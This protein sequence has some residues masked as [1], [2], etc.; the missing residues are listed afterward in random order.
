ME[1]TSTISSPRGSLPFHRKEEFRSHDV[2][3]LDGADQRTIELIWSL[4]GSVDEKTNLVRACKSD[5]GDTH[6]V[7]ACIRNMAWLSERELSPCHD[8][9]ALSE[10][11]P[12]GGAISVDL[13]TLLGLQKDL[14]DQVERVVI[15]LLVKANDQVKA[16]GTFRPG[17]MTILDAIASM[18]VSKDGRFDP[19]VVGIL[20]QELD[21]PVGNRVEDGLS[22]VYRKYIASQLEELPE[23]ASLVHEASDVPL[24]AH[25]RPLM[26]LNG[27]DL[28]GAAIARA[29]AARIVM[30]WRCWSCP[31]QREVPSCWLSPDKFSIHETDLEALLKQLVQLLQ[32]GCICY[33]NNDYGVPPTVP[34]EKGP[35]LRQKVAID[36]SN[37]DD[38]I[39]HPQLKLVLDTSCGRDE[40]EEERKT[41]I[42][43]AAQWIPA[44]GRPG[45]PPTEHVDTLDAWIKAIAMC[46][47][48]IGPRALEDASTLEKQSLDKAELT[49]GQKELLRRWTDFCTM[50][51]RARMATFSLT[52]SPLLKAWELTYA[53]SVTKKWCDRSWECIKTSLLNDKSLRSMVGMPEFLEALKQSFMENARYE[54]RVDRSPGH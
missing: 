51:T 3:E 40:P 42:N 8:V 11:F 15:G 37:L 19:N 23:L 7:S 6:A 24:P 21:R 35:L 44:D 17:A 18:L 30:V 2:I 33:G 50:Q 41:L 43:A 26:F 45:H 38:C 10:C 52:A 46:R 29:D 4:H 13:P 49:A 9:T 47:A 25:A 14:A 22:S 16:E 39:S 20:I 1:S 5:P 54:Y 48:G 53:K 34:I 36:V 28:T 12:A 31:R 27:E 32:L